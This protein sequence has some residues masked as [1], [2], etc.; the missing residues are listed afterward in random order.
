[1]T[2]ATHRLGVRPFKDSQNFAVHITRIYVYMGNLQ[3][4][5]SGFFRSGSMFKKTEIISA[6]RG[7][8]KPF[9]HGDAFVKY[10]DGT[11]VVL[12]SSLPKHRSLR[13]V[14]EQEITMLQ[15]AITT[16]QRQLRWRSGSYCEG[17]TRQEFKK[18]KPFRL[19]SNAEAKR[20]DKKTEQDREKAR[21]LYHANKHTKAEVNH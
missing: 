19:T 11:M 14:N 16:V 9:T 8:Q 6:S 3:K 18:R 5:H 21:R 4:N 2:K 10:S 17:N 20:R 7:L 15:Q 13:V 1:M 12:D